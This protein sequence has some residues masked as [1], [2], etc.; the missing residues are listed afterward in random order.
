LTKQKGK[1]CEV[2]NTRPIP[3]NDAGGRRTAIPWGFKAGPIRCEGGDGVTFAA[4]DYGRVGLS[5]GVFSKGMIRLLRSRP[6]E[7]VSQVGYCTSTG[8]YDPAEFREIS[9][10][11]FQWDR[12]SL[13][14]LGVLPIRARD[15]VCR[16]FPDEVH[17][18]NLLALIR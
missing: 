5:G 10:S 4:K 13:L 14:R 3:K 18:N 2:V 15:A 17:D 12:L 11:L 1:V 7:F 6:G 9:G 16:D 8:L